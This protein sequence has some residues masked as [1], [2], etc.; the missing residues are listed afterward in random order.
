MVNVADLFELWAEIAGLDVGKIVPRSRVLDS[1]W[2]LPYLTQ[3]SRPGVRHYNFAQTGINFTA[4]GARPGPCVLPMALFPPATQTCT[5]LMADKQSCMDEGGRLT[6]EQARNYSLRRELDRLLA[7]EVACP[8]DGNKDGVVDEVD[9]DNWASFNG[10]GSS[11]YDFPGS[12]EDGVS[13]YDGVTDERDLQVILEHVGKCRRSRR[14]RGGGARGE[15]RGGP[16]RVPIAAPH[17]CRLVPD[18]RAGP[19]YLTL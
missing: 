5:Q 4:N 11:W 10:V 8:G 15:P 6:P 9:V 7:S 17:A 3:P 16:P 18:P 12:N 2:M 1:V 14:A 19:S 13:V